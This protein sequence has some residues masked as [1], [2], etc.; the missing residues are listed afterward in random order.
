MYLP[1]AMY[2]H[3]VTS[4]KHLSYHRSTGHG[5]R[6]T[7]WPSWTVRVSRLRVI[8]LPSQPNAW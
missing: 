6:R 5:A 8:H 4:I 3:S 2:L 7:E 1:T